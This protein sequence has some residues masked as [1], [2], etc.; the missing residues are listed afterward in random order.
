MNVL[1]MIVWE[2]ACMGL[3][4][5]MFCRLIHVDRSTKPEVRAALVITSL[6]SLVGIAAPLYNWVVDAIT[7]IVV[8]PLVLLELILSK[9]WAHG[10]P[11]QF[12]KGF[13]HYK[14]RM[15]DPG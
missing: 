3:L 9:N 7:I 13:H 2:L 5:S 10:I 8:C 11:A 12:T 1:L 15:G 6:A 4:W 14:R